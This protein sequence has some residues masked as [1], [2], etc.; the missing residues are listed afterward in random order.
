MLRFSLP[1]TMCTMCARGE[2]EVDHS[3][4]FVHVP[5]GCWTVCAFLG[6]PGISAK[7]QGYLW[8]CHGFGNSWVGHYDLYITTCRGVVQNYQRLIFHGP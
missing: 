7:I 4:V 5:G 1:C 8:S 6:Y 2:L 3:T